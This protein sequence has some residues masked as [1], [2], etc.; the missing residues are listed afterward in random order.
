MEADRL[1]GKTKMERNTVLLWSLVAVAAEW[2]ITQQRGTG[3]T[4]Y[5]AAA[6]DARAMCAR[7]DQGSTTYLAKNLVDALASPER[8]GLVG[9]LEDIRDEI[10]EVPPERDDSRKAVNAMISHM[11]K[12]GEE[13][14]EATKVVRVFLNRT[15]RGNFNA[16]AAYCGGNV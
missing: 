11:D 13:F 5:G 3:D 7:Y 2:A 10:A 1:T 8:R 6:N 14:I 12:G 16:W 15:W 9:A 4:A